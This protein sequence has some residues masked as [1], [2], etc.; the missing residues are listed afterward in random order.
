MRIEQRAAVHIQLILIGI[1]HVAVRVFVDGLCHLIE[2]MLWDGVVMVGQNDE[3]SLRHP[4]GRVGVA[5]NAQVISQLRHMEA[6]VLLGVLCHDA[7]HNR[8]LTLR[9]S[10]GHAYLPVSV[11][12]GQNGV[13]HLPQILL[14]SLVGRN[15]NG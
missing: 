1:D 8:A 2:R 10:V 5:G 12:L 3:I 4:E 15:D 7:A 9:A 11:G 6:A 13:Q 14:R